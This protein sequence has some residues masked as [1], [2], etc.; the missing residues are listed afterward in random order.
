MKKPTIKD[1]YKTTNAIYQCVETDTIC[2]NG[3]EIIYDPVTR[4]KFLDTFGYDKV[5]ESCG[6]LQLKVW[7]NGKISKWEMSISTATEDVIELDYLDVKLLKKLND[8][9]NYALKN[10]VEEQGEK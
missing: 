5:G 7:N 6:H 10:I 4:A 8:F 2:Y 9:L 1:L 3:R